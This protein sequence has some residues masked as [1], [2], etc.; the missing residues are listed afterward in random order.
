MGTIGSNNESMTTEI[1]KIK[2]TLNEYLNAFFDKDGKWVPNYENEYL[3]DLLVMMDPNI[4]K[5]TSIV[6]KDELSKLP[7][8]QINIENNII[9]GLIVNKRKQAI[10]KSEGSNSIKKETICNQI[11]HHYTKIYNILVCIALTISRPDIK[12][13]ERKKLLFDERFKTLYNP[14]RNESSICDY[15]YLL[16][17]FNETSGLLSYLRLH[18]EFG[19]T[20]DLNDRIKLKIPLDKAKDKRNKL[21]DFNSNIRRVSKMNLEGGSYLN[22]NNNN[23]SNNND[24]LL[25]N[26]DNLLNNNDNLSN[27]DD[28]LSNNNDNLS[29]NNE[30]NYLNEDCKNENNSP[31]KLT[32][33]KKLNFANMI[34]YSKILQ[35]K[36]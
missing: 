4:C 23:L 36:K 5:D 14:K 18:E 29:N 26:N 24:N 31:F 19:L 28:N 32:K 3:R 11:G 10:I 20:E 13:S 2:N 12:Y 1:E 27:N 25:N 33:K 9:N 22:N 35:A 21:E 16:K 15:E 34:A 17:N 8:W 7:N 6:L 30:K